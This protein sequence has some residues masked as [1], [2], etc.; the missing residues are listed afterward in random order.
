MRIDQ[1]LP[2]DGNLFFH[3]LHR[4]AGSCGWTQIRSQLRISKTNSLSADLTGKLSLEAQLAWL[5]VDQGRVLP[6]P[7]IAPPPPGLVGPVAVPADPPPAL[8]PNP[9]FDGAPGLG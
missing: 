8:L 1:Q 6:M 4:A 5:W 9:E 3:Q 2:V 7:E